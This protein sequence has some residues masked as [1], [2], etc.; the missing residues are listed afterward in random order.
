[1][2]CYLHTNTKVVN[3]FKNSGYVLNLKFIFNNRKMKMSI[4]LM[5]RIALLFVILTNGILV[6]AQEADIKSANA[7]I[8]KAE[9]LVDID[10]SI[11]AMEV[12]DQA[13]S[14]NPAVTKL[15]YYLGYV[16]LKTGEN[17][18]ALKT[19]EKGVSLN[20]KDAINHVGLG[21]IRMIEKKPTEAKVFFDK[22]LALSKSK[23]VA[24]LQAI[25]EA[26]LVDAK[27]AETA[28]KFLEKA[29]SLDPN[30]PKTYML[31][32]E[33]DLFQNKGGPAI[34]NCERAARLYPSNGKPY[35]NIALVYMRSQNYALAEENFQKAISV[36]S[37]F[38]LAYKELGEL[39][40]SMKDGEK[41][42]KAYESYLKMTENPEEGMVRYA[43]FLFMS[44]NYAKATEV[45]R[46]QLEKPDVTPTT[47]KYAAYA[48][49]EAG[50]LAEAQKV[51]EKY[52][53]AVPV[54]KIEA[55]D[56]S[57]NGKLLQK[58]NQDSLAVISFRKS[59]ALNPAQEDIALLCAEALLKGKRFPESIEAYVSL[60]K[61]R[62]KPL[63][64]DYYG[65]GR[66][67]YYNSQFEKA[68]TAF[69]K[70]IEMQ[71]ARTIGYVWM[72]KVKANQD[73]NSEQGLAKPFFE[74]VIEIGSIEPEKNK[75][76][77]ID[78][79]KYLGYY[80]Y[81]KIEIPVSISFWKKVL[82]LDSSDAQ[83]IGVLKELK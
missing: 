28:L 48:E 80:H 55:S 13:I 5:K 50:N 64:L 83:A 37:E 29:K 79:Y 46:R 65:L 18:K 10:Q 34:S 74:K 9:R 40:Y 31:M 47:L 72:S 57:Y 77:L 62:K 12:L 82:E 22:A 33:V 19:F 76:D 27:Y 49:V 81:L 63:S 25:A 2:V 8:K 70:L 43:F 42:V 53:A 23:D 51:F 68:D 3:T 7:E 73:P 24:V 54:D 1:M 36:D 32:G 38:T 61:I 60:M 26:Y 58:L 44:K 30:N 17:G 56:Y 71:P 4:D 41:A 20:D 35:Y 78:A 39:Y 14:A 52:F 16:Q 66:A 6:I 21:A 59:L 69:Q 15:Y 75:K 67:Y 11:K 45:F